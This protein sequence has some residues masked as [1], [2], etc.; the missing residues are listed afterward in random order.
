MSIMSS[1]LPAAETFVSGVLLP[2]VPL[3]VLPVSVVLVGVSAPPTLAACFAA[4]SA[5]RFCFEAEGGMME[6]RV[7]EKEEGVVEDL[8]ED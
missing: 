4:F 8:E 3:P 2:F 6:V 5:R 1:V 7:E